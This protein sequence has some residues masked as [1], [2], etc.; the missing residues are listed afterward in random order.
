MVSWWFWEACSSIVLWVS[1]L[2]GGA[3][4]LVCFH[5][6]HHLLYSVLLPSSDQ[7]SMTLGPGLSKI[8]C[9]TT[10]PSN[11]G[12]TSTPSRKPSLTDLF[13]PYW[14]HFSF[15][16]SYNAQWHSYL[17]LLIFGVCSSLSNGLGPSGGAVT[18]LHFACVT[19]KPLHHVE[20][21]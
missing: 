18:S 19:Q 8:S 20:Y 1:L 13:S 7:N 14:F 11:H 17:L 6:H 9:Q 15:P 10:L 16:N 21:T 5:T 3:A 4:H 12:S 2:Q